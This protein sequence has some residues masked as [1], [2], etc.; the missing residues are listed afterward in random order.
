VIT[1]P[2]LSSPPAFVLL[3]V[4]VGLAAYLRQ[5][6]ESRSQLIDDIEYEKDEIQSRFPLGESHTNTKLKSLKASRRNLRII[7]PIV[8]W[9]TIIIVVRLTLLAFARWWYPGDDDF[10]GIVFRRAD[11]GVMCGL[12]VIFVG[13]WYM[14]CAGRRND[15]KLQPAIDK[16]KAIVQKRKA[17]SQS[18]I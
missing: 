5:L 14:H 15:K 11:F 7:A 10:L 16:W 8:I 1:Q 18:A 3:G 17:E 9:F 2:M 12:T 6:G 13:L 4:A